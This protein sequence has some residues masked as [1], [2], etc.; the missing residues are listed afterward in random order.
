MDFFRSSQL[1]NLL[2]LSVNIV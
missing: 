2:C 1:Q